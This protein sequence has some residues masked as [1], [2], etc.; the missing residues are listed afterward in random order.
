MKNAGR[1]VENK[2]EQKAL[3]NIGIGTPATRAPL[4][5][6]YS[7]ETISLG[8]AKSEKGLQVYGLVKDKKIANVQMTA[9]WEMVLDRIEKGELNANQFINDIQHYTA[10]ITSELLSLSIP[11]ENIPH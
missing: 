6:R 8:K 10:E 1:S 7:A 9:E 4:L 5:K 2:E 11:Q 3:S